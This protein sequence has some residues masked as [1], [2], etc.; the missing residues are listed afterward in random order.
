MS[1]ITHPDNEAERMNEAMR[2]V[3]ATQKATAV[4]NA[5]KEER[6]TESGRKDPNAPLSAGRLAW[7]AVW[8]QQKQ[9]WAWDHARPVGNF[10]KG[11]TNPIPW[12]GVVKPADW[13]KFELAAEDGK[14]P[15]PV[16]NLRIRHPNAQFMTPRRLQP[17]KDVVYAAAEPQYLVLWA[18]NIE[19]ERWL[20]AEDL[21][22]EDS[23]WWN[24]YQN[25]FGFSGKGTAD[26]IRIEGHGGPGAS[27]GSG[28]A[29]ADVME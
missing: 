27:S 9:P 12:I 7:E 15:V 2:V 23:Y 5:L 28:M 1:P 18:I 14:P 3:A 22:T 21:M 19:E 6:E 13:E 16:N 4:A 24:V 29:T 17:Y 26:V 20:E 11:Y 10:P 25:E 8:H